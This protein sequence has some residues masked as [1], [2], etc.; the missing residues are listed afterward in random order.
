LILSEGNVS[1][2]AA[3]CVFNASSLGAF[4]QQVENTVVVG[5]SRGHWEGNT[6][7]YPRPWTFGFDVKRAIFGAV[8][9]TRDDAHD[10]QWEEACYEG[11]Q[12]VDYSLR[13][14]RDEK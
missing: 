4:G 8:S 11:V 2:F 12:P 5:D 7:A 9:P 14:E 10:E 1:K 6:S 3:I 13:S